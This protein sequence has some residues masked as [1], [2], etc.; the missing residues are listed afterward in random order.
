[1]I[2]DNVHILSSWPV[3]RVSPAELSC[4]QAMIIG[5]QATNMPTDGPQSLVHT[6]I[7]RIHLTVKDV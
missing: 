7:Q 3:E 4:Q 6:Q 5:L 1:M 2:V